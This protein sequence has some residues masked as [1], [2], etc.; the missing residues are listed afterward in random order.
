SLDTFPLEYGEII[1]AHELVYGDNPFI[2]ATIAADDVRRACEL[3]AKSHLVHL[4]EAF[5]ESGGKPTDVAE[6]VAT[7]APAFT[8]LLRNVAR[9][10]RVTTSDRSE[11]TRAGAR[12]VGIPEELVADMLNLE[13]RPGVPATDPSRLFPEYL[14]AVEQLARAV[15]GWRA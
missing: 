6:L 12:A 13:R 1:R 10:N 5:I 7:S 3:Q 4:R 9:L 11:V 14:A 8:Q 2:S 15:D